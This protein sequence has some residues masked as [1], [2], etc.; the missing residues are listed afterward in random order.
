MSSIAALTREIEKYEQEK[1]VHSNQVSKLHQQT[2]NDITKGDSF[3]A[4]SDEKEVVKEKTKIDAIDKEIDKLKAQITQLQHEAT[5]VEAKMTA[6]RNQHDSDITN[7]EQKF[8]TD[9]QQL[10]SEHA[11]ILG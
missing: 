2:Q 5:N 11:R 3:G 9:M 4:M 1:S 6:R 10:E 7:L 8:K